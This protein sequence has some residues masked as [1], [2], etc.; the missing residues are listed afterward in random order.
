MDS[1]S[2]MDLNLA[3]G[4]VNLAGKLSGKPGLPRPPQTQQ[5]PRGAALLRRNMQNRGQLQT[6]QISM[7]SSFDQQATEVTLNP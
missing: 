5:G 2:N 3:S 7:R 6:R 1:G 4:S